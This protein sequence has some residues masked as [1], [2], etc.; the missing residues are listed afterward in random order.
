MIA[1]DTTRHDASL[2]DLSLRLV[3]AYLQEVRS[4][5]YEASGEL[6]FYDLCARM[7]IVDGPR[8]HARPRNVGLLF[9]S[10]EPRRFFP[11]VQIDVVHFPEGKTGEI[12]EQRFAGP[13]ASQLRE[14]LAFIRRAFL[15]ERV[16][17]RP[18]RAEADRILPFPYA[19]VEEALANA[20]Y[21]RGY[22]MREPIEVQVTPGEMTITSYP[23]PDRSVRIDDLNAGGVV[24]RRY[25]NRRIGEFLKELRLTEGRGTGVPTIFKAMQENGSPPPRFDT[26]EERSYFTTTLPVHPAFVSGTPGPGGGGGSRPG[27]A[28]L[29][30]LRMSLSPQQRVVLQHALGFAGSSHFRKAYLQPLIDMGLLALTVPD[31]PRSVLQRYVTTE[32][33]REILEEVESPDASR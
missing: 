22:D 16:R 4:D 28:A 25:R 19:A 14:A 27:P 23:G 11:G 1:R 17:K 3:Q 12:R 13:L 21:H 29:R 9:F 6:S 30:I 10:D 2:A 15:V 18:D 8:E 5:L 26:D 24:A 32:R 33:G 20:V 7:Q 31:R